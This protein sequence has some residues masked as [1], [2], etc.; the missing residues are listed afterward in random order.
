[1]KKFIMP[2]YPA[3]IGKFE[4]QDSYAKHGQ[5]TI[6]AMLES[7]DCNQFGVVRCG[8]GGGYMVPLDENFESHPVEL[9]VFTVKPSREYENAAEV[10]EDT[11]GIT[12]EEMEEAWNDALARDIAD[13]EDAFRL[14]DV[15]VAY[16]F[17]TPEQAQAWLEE[18]NEEKGD[19]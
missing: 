9:L 6:A 8:M 7:G 14:K 3:V 4:D 16:L 12:C 15:P 2:Q 19:A 1:M 17:E 18:Y 11:W 13:E 10:V 5:A